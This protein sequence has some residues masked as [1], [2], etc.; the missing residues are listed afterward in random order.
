MSEM[1]Y[2]VYGDTFSGILLRNIFDEDEGEHLTLQIDVD[3]I[4]DFGIEVDDRCQKSV[5]FAAC[6]MLEEQYD[7]NCDQAK[8]DEMYL[9]QYNPEKIL[10]VYRLIKTNKRLTFDISYQSPRITETKSGD[11]N[12]TYFKATNG[13]EVISC[14]RMD[15][16]SQKIWLHG[17]EDDQCADRSGSLVFPNNA[18]R[19]LEYNQFIQALNEWA[20][21]NNGEVIKI[22]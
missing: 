9:T 8:I 16:H 3:E 14:S 15:L 6:Q 22:G 13:V 21:H 2:T 20:I 1:K 19:D 5:F 10:L 18:K 17:A 11:E 7:Y 12:R 4:R